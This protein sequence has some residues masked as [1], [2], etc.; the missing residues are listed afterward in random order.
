MSIVLTD[1]F[2]TLLNSSGT[3]LDTNGYSYN[4]GGQRTQQVFTVGNKMWYA[5]DAIGQ[6]TNASGLKPTDVP[7]LQEQFAYSYDA[8][9]N[10]SEGVSPIIVTF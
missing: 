1:P 4:L 2:P 6:L 9:H 5:Y 7:R 10:L 3:P 8:A